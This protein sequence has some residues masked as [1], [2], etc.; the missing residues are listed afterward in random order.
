MGE[1]WKNGAIPGKDLFDSKGPLLHFIYL[2]GSYICPGKIGIYIL[3]SLFMYFSISMLI[4]IGKLITDSKLIIY[5]AT[6]VFLILYYSII[7]NGGTNEH[8]SL[9][10]AIYPIFVSAK[11]FFKGGKITNIN[12]LLCGICFAIVSQIRLNNTAIIIGVCIALL[13]SLI[14]N[15]EFTALLKLA[16]FFVLGCII[17]YIPLVIYFVYNDALNDMIYMSIL[18]NIKYKQNWGGEMT[19]LKYRTNISHLLSCLLLPF[20]SY[21][22]DKKSNSK[23]F[24][25]CFSISIITLLTFVSGIGY[26]HY[27][28]MQLPIA[29]MCVIMT[30][31]LKLIGKIFVICILNVH[32]ITYSRAQAQVIYST[33]LSTNTYK[34]HQDYP[35]Y[36]REIKFTNRVNLQ[37]T[38][39]SYI[40]KSERNSIYIF[41]NMQYSS[42]FIGTPYYPAGKYFH[43]Q[44]KIA[45]TDKIAKNDIIKSFEKAS[46]K[47]IVSDTHISDCQ[48]LARYAHRYE[49]VKDTCINDYA[50][51]QLI[52][53]H[54]ISE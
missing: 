37:N 31:Y 36:N 32:T 24:A 18:Y 41:N 26:K 28:I 23:S 27:Y 10:F 42:I 13:Y 44:D 38:I 12:A 22:Y 5:T 50:P 40:P 17:I 51:Q 15:K 4:K 1:G 14:R 2:I 3:D 9:P 19:L 39:F 20:L 52:I 25:L 11:Y 45:I 34:N 8:Y 48:V 35:D 7:G 49:T 6:S 47:W 33:I 21:Y 53:Y 54:K 46:P 30:Y 43:L 16:G 29:F